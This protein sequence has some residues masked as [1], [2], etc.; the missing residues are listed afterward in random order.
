MLSQANFYLTFYFIAGSLADQKL[1]PFGNGWG[2]R[3]F[4]FLRFLCVLLI[5]TQ[6]IVCMGNRP[7]GARRMFLSSMIAYAVIMAYTTFCAT[8]IVIKSFAGGVGIEKTD[9]T[10]G[11][12]LFTNLIISV[13]ST[14][15]VYFLMSFLYLDPWHMFTSS[16]QYFMMLPSYICTLQVYAFCNT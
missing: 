12:N 16:A 9:F 10:L 1:D 13:G 11:D 15:G 3:I 8:Y 6:F 2:G 5:C 7:Q 14:M 4:V